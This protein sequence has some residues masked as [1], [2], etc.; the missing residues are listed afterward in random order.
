M[1]GWANKSLT[2]IG[3]G[4][5]RKNFITEQFAKLIGGNSHLI[6]GYDLELKLCTASEATCH[7]CAYEPCKLREAIPLPMRV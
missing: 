1:F 2:L 5:E 7:L 4:G 3:G 6:V